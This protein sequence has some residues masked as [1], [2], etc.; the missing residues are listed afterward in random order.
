MSPNLQLKCLLTSLIKMCCCQFADVPQKCC[1]EC[2]CGTR[3]CAGA[4]WEWDSP[5]EVELSPYV[6]KEGWA[7]APDWAAMDWPPQNG[8]QVCTPWPINMSLP[9]CA[10]CTKRTFQLTWPYTSDV[11]AAL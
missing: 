8:S 10:L 11:R 1:H 3:A 7:Y 9:P 4:G 2:T 6:D 5:W